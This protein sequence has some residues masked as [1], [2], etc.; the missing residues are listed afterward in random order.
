MTKRVVKRVVPRRSTAVS[1]A[2]S[3]KGWRARKRL[4]KNKK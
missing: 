4:A 3:K 2:A 1:I